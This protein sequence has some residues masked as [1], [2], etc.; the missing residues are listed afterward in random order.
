MQESMRFT[1]FLYRVYEIYI[2]P[3]VQIYIH[4]HTWYGYGAQQLVYTIHKPE[5]TIA[6]KEGPNYYVCVYEW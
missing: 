3:Y 4:V 2:L 5:Q 1:F 6:Q